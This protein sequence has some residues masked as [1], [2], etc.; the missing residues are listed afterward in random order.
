MVTRFSWLFETGLWLI[1][2]CFSVRVINL[3]L[4]AGFIFFFELIYMICFTSWRRMLTIYVTIGRACWRSVIYSKDD[5]T[6]V[7][8]WDELQILEIHLIIALSADCSPSGF[9][10]TT[11]SRA[12][13]RDGAGR[14]WRWH[15]WSGSLISP[16]S[17][18]F[19]DNGWTNSRGIKTGVLIGSCMIDAWKDWR[20][21][22]FGSGIFSTNTS[23]FICVDG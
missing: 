19:D 20:C 7:T 12:L 3:R 21:G 16:W 8:F 9:Y 14:T 2:F 4:G 6:S 15:I 23:C 1:S 5:L 11:C 22:V 13:S 17:A 18:R 10:L